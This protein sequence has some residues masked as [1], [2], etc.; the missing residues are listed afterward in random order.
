MPSSTYRVPASRFSAAYSPRER[1]SSGMVKEA[2]LSRLQEGIERCFVQWLR[3]YTYTYIIYTVYR[4]ASSSSSD[5]IP[6]ASSSRG[7]L[8]PLSFL[9]NPRS[10]I[11]CASGTD[12]VR[13]E[14]STAS[15]TL[16]LLLKVGGTI[17]CNNC[18]MYVHTLEYIHYRNVRFREGPKMER[19]IAWTPI[20][21]FVCGP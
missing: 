8:I 7:R 9:L 21:K 12:P 3:I 4:W 14:F 19:E 16:A 2:L 18:L 10:L 20:D 13:T 17:Y 6:S 15:L 1:R 5:P 11:L